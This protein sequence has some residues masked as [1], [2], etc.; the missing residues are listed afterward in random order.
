MV[1]RLHEIT[2]SDLGDHPDDEVSAGGSSNTDSASAKDPE[3]RL[4]KQP[5]GPFRG[6]RSHS[7]GITKHDETIVAKPPKKKVRKS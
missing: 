7:K 1:G 3:E 2:A 6:T 5:D 4:R